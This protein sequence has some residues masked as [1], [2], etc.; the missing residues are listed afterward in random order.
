MHL[1]LTSSPCDDNVP[2]GV[3][4]PCIFF[5]RNDFVE[6]LRRCIK[7]GGNLLVIAADPENDELNDEML[8]TFFKC[9]AW[10]E[11]SLSGA[12]LLDGRNAQDAAELVEASDVIILGGGHVPTENAF[13]QEIGLKELLADYQGVVMGISAGSMNCASVVY[14]QPE[15]PGEAV[16]P[17]Y[18]RFIDGLG[19]TEIM[20][21]PHYQKVKDYMIDGMRLYEDVTY[22]DSYGNAF[23]AIPDGS[24]VLED[25]D[26]C[27]LFGE[28]YLI[29]EGR[30]EQIC[31]DGE[32]V[33]L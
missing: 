2:A 13:F 3:E 23:V 33:E 24:Y 16:D 15:M 6:N 27:F 7:P 22:S 10:H 26:G 18:N 31:W 17:E 1:F 5:E 21:L 29:T 11:L 4:L 19:L 32:C 28:G 20:I 9:F 14:A 30:M 8:H 25:E 12:Q